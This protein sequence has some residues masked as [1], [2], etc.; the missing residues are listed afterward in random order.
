MGT[1]SS[2]INHSIIPKSQTFYK[3]N[4]V[5]ITKTEIMKMIMKVTMKM[6]KL[7]KEREIETEIERDVK[8]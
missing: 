3:N 1:R 5:I 4:H 7:K 2:K 6:K 8:R